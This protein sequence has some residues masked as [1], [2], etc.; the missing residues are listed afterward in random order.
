MTA[1]CEEVLKLLKGLALRINLSMR[2]LPAS[3]WRQDPIAIAIPMLVW[4]VR[5]SKLQP[6]KKVQPFMTS[7]PKKILGSALAP[8]RIIADKAIPD[9]G[10]KNVT[11]PGGKEINCPIISGEC[12][13]DRNRE[14]SNN[15]IHK[16]KLAAFLTTILLYVHFL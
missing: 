2:Y 1:N 5:A 11:F 12:I 13:D 10:H 15:H 3:G 6:L 8:N 9:G 4:T 16:I 14:S 7:A